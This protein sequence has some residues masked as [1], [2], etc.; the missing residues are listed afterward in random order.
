[1]T[2][3]TLAAGRRPRVLVTHPGADLYGSDRVLLETVAGFQAADVDVLVALPGPGPL[4]AELQ[5]LGAHVVHVRMPVVRKSALRPRGLLEFL[6]DVAR[7]L[8]AQARLLRSWRPDLIFVNTIT[9]P[10]WLLLARLTRRPSI[11]HV[12]EAEQSAPRLLRALLA[13]PLLLA[14][15]LVANSRF[16]AR[17]LAASVPGLTRRTEVVYN[18]VAGPPELTPARAVLED[19]VRLVYVGRLSPRKGP[20]VA[21]EALQLLVA[22]GADVHLELLGAV[23]T[24]YEWFEQELR[25]YVAAHGLG[26]RV[27][28]AGFDRDVWPHIQR[29]DI[30]LVPSVDDEP[31]GNTAVE[32]VL[33]ARPAVVSAT[34][35]LLEAAD[36]YGSVITVAPAQ[37][38]AIA[39]AVRRIVAD[40]PRFADTAVQD[41][42]AAQ[43]RHSTADYQRRMVAVLHEL[44]PTAA[45]PAAT[46]R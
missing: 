17:V 1:M 29:A 30:M 43:A 33:C 3:R 44:L 37:P 42:Q 20:A 7:G 9:I 6:A 23:F 28:F 16:S 13:L 34:T 15:R 12:H 11:C 21:L 22:G 40:W 32:A 25:G 24:G 8:P 46:P 35:G 10:S 4:V 36:G 14:D 31:F 18:A 5:A 27:V 41:A 19:P 26:D 2:V 38:A 39:D 45:D